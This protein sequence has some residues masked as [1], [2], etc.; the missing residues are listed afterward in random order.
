VSATDRRELGWAELSD[1]GR[2]PELG[3]L[4]A[5]MWRT[6]RHPA[7][8]WT[9]VVL[10]MLD[11]APEWDRLYRA[12][13]WFLDIVPRFT[14][15][16]IAPAL[17]VGPAH[18]APDP[19]FELSYH[20]RRV[21]LP[22]PGTMEQ[23]LAFA[24]GQGLTPLDRTRPPWIGTLVEGLE[25]GRAAYV[26]QAHHVLMDGMAVTQLFSRVMSPQRETT[27]D[28]PAG[29]PRETEFVSP[30]DVAGRSLAQQAQSTPRLFGR[31]IGTAR[32]SL[33]HPRAA[34]RYASSLGHVLAPPPPNPSQILQGKSRRVWR[35]GTL[36]CSLADLRAAGKAVGGTVN[37]TFVSALLGGLRYYCA[38]LGEDLQDVPISMPVSM[39]TPDKAMGGNK[40]AGAFFSVPTSIADPAERIREMHRRV[41]A[42]RG[43][44]ALDFLGNLTP[45]LNRTPS[46]I[47]AGL[48]GS[49][50]ARSMLTTS[51]WP[52]LQEEL[53]IA[54]AK[55]ERMFVLAPL[56]GTSMTG[57]MCTHAGICCIGIN[58]DG[59]VFE[60]PELLWECTQRSLDE[61]LALGKS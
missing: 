52:G 36:E 4:D 50:N 18:W 20:L 49:I 48:L 3:E 32:N 57:A 30:L 15:R 27:P 6:E 25:G 38:E 54:G 40:F 58:V 55:F 13:Q 33:L 28:K 12:H 14:E 61:V 2:E 16:V 53:F 24:Q 42:V 41:E 23:L 10:L 21:C 29:A 46:G 26:M 1:W 31:L 9:G 34:A 45:F 51:S 37:D 56:P 59:E 5:L 44:P 22:A 47:A 43:E 11:R 60:Q 39:R 8:S 19:S 7:N 35:F 17:P